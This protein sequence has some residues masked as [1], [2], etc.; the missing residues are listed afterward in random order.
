MLP[1]VIKSSTLAHP[2][3]EKRATPNATFV[4]DPTVF[5]FAEALMTIYLRPS[6]SGFNSGLLSGGAYTTETIDPASATR[7]SS[8]TSYL[9]CAIQNAQLKVYNRALAS[10]ETEQ[11]RYD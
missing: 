4:S 3:W 8:Q 1:F 6:R 9:T 11:V 10:K 5:Y 2:E 7:S